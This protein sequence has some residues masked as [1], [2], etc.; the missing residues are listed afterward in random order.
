[1]NDRSAS[2][3]LVTALPV[4]LVLLALIGAVI[5]FPEGSLLDIRGKAAPVTIAPTRIPLPTIPATP[6]TIYRLPESVCS[7][8]YKP[9]CSPKTNQT[10]S[11]ECEARLANALPIRSGACPTTTKTVTPAILPQTR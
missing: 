9:V 1:M 4:L 11:S 3:I 6:T 8:L 10:Y 7:D 5:F 2:E